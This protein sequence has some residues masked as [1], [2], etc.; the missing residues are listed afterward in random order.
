MYIRK[1][2]N[3][4]VIVFFVS[5]DTPRRGENVRSGVCMLYYYPIVLDQF[6]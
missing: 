2:C 3:L 4:K 6:P 1:N 5:M